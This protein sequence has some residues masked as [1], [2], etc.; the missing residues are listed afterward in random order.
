MLGARSG[1]WVGLDG[2]AAAGEGWSEPEAGASVVP[3]EGLEAEPPEG[4]RS[5]P[6]AGPE[7]EPAAGAAT[8]AAPA[9]GSRLV[10]GPVERAGADFI[11][12][13]SPPAPPA[14]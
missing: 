3:A 11:A 12:T 4:L 9:A 7:A 8:E 10:S 13:A 6:G 5:E 14:L 1:A 2:E